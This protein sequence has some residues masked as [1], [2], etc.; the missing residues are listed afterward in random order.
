MIR[1]FGYL[2]ICSIRNTARL[3]I[4]RLRQPRY[5]LMTLGFLLYLGSIVFR[6]PASGAFGFFALGD[7]RAQMIAA[8][9]A[10]LM[11]GSAWVLPVGAALRF[12][13]A[14]IQ[15]L[16]TAPITR[17]QL[18]GYKVCRLLLGAAA[19]GALLTVFVGP[20]RLVPALLFAAK[21]VMVLA[22][23]TLHGAGVATYR[24]SA[25]DQGHLPLRRWRLLAAACLLT[26]VVG[27]GLAFLAL[28]SG[29][30]LMAAVPVAVLLLAANALWII[31]SD[32]AF[33]EAATEAADR[34]SRAVVTGQFSIP[35][36]SRKRSS[37]FRLAARGPAETAILWKNWLLL[38]RTSRR[39]IVVSA[40]VL[41][42]IVAGVV[43]A[44]HGVM[45][46]EVV[47]GVSMLFVALAALFGPAMIRIDL[48][49]DLG[50]LALIKTWPVRGSAVIRGELL[51]PAIA[52]SLCAAVAICIGSAF[53][54]GLL[55]VDQ[56]G[57]GARVMFAI[58]AVLAA[59]AVIVAQLVVH[60]GIAVAFPA[61]VELK[62]AA[63]AAA[64]EMNG[65]MMIVMY[66]SLLVLAVVLVV[67]AAAA[68]AAYFVAGGVFI[69]AS[70]FA[71]LLIGESLAATEIIGRML[72]RTDLQDVA[73]SE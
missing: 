52:L 18:I 9:V 65:R 68:V 1:T 64:M 17:R 5:L 16:F 7:V 35:R 6:R 47:G 23:L 11:L 63:G 10:T 54:P 58:S 44:S 55:F 56:A 20:P 53:A 66:G 59:T 8:G 43:V 24:S 51:A 3:R 19:S 61:W 50:H 13:S 2:T 22:V 14:E 46:A 73:V 32:S 40:I 42:S 30:T 33:E 29:V 21:S 31:R 15:F 45:D 34:M 49:H 71:V 38:G 39:T 25:R 36:I 70:I 72:D 12:T 60:N 57:A 69:P 67:P 27:A 62:P 41:C 28:S 48:R 26:P 4:R 37:S